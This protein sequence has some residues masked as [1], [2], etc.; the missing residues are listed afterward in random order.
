MVAEHF[1]NRDEFFGE[2]II[3]S[4]PR[5]DPDFARQRYWKGAIWPPLNFLAYLGFRNYGFT[6]AQAV[7]AERSAALFVKEWREKGLIGENY[8]SVSGTADDPALSSDPCHSWGTLLGM[9]A[10]IEKGFVGRP[11]NPLPPER[12]H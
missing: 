2:W 9:I 1:F 8:S 12:F 11:E 10:F 3:P 7:L 5:N 6:R 4:V